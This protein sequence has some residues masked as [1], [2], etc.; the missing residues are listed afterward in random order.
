MNYRLFVSISLGPLSLLLTHS[1]QQANEKHI[2]HS[3][4][5]F[6]S[7]RGGIDV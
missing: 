3:K 7:M 6:I 5:S 1:T 4:L 2:F